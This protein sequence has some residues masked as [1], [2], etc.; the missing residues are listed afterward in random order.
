M[1]D[2]GPGNH[3]LHNLT[4]RWYARLSRSESAH[5][6]PPS[7]AVPFP[8]DLYDELDADNVVAFERQPQMLRVSGD[9]RTTIRSVP[10]RYVG[11][12]A[13]HPQGIGGP[14]HGRGKTPSTPLRLPVEAQEAPA[15]RFH[16][17]VLPWS[18]RLIAAVGLLMLV[19]LGLRLI[20]LPAPTLDSPLGVQATHAAYTKVLAGQLPAATE[21]GGFLLG[22]PPWN[23]VAPTN[24]LAGLPVFNWFSALGAHLGVPVEWVGRALSAVFSAVA[25]LALFAVVRRTA[26]SLAAVYA[27]LFFAVAPLSV[28]LGQKFSPATTIIAVQALA[29]L[30]LLGWRDTVSHAKPQGS[31]GRFL[32][33]LSMSGIA[34][35]VDPGSLFLAL[36]AAYLV[37]SV[38]GERLQVGLQG[39]NPRVAV[40]TWGDA[41]HRSAHRGKVVAYV[42]TLLIA[43]GAW[44]LYS[45][46]VDVLVL[47]AGDGV[48]GPSG[49]I[50][51]LFNYGT[52][53][54]LTGMTIG[55]VLSVIG[56]LLLVAGML[57]GA[58]QGTRGIFNVWLAAALLHALLDAGRLAR[59]DD[60]LLP[61]LLPACALV[62]IGASWAGTLPARVWRAITEQQ[63]DPVSEYAVSPH[64]AWLLD[65]PETPA[66]APAARPQA[67]P[68]LGRSVAA[69]T[70]KAGERAR[71]ASLMGFGH[72]AVLG[73]I[74]LVALSG[75]QAAWASAQVSTD[76]VELEAAGREIASISAPGSQIVIVGP[77]A[78]ELFYASGR[79]GWALDEESFSILEIAR[80]QRAGASYLLSADQTWLGQHP[81]YV[82]LLANYSVKQLA[83]RYILFD[84]NTKPS[85]NDRLYFLESGHTLG[86]AFRRYWETH[87]GVQKLGYPISEEVSEQNPLDGQVRI[88]QYFERAVLEHHPEFGG[89]QDEVMLAAVGLWVTKDRYFQQVAPFESTSERAYF[90]QTG[91]SVKE[92]FL[93][94]WNQQG[95]LA[96]FGYP[97]SEELP[98]IS[99]ADGKV[100]TVQYFERARFEWHPADA[101]TPNEV[102]LGLIGKQALEM[103]K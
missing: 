85:A 16:A 76:A 46:K 73:A 54:Q 84:L 99:P 31:T 51:N 64:T 37:L 39:R 60:V 5:S 49:L 18:G 40:A 78:P 25:A 8:P 14:V 11:R 89:T 66:E 80:L 13:R 90:P 100:Y 88:V 71:R 67:R 63:R 74:G 23:G 92:A 29:I 65:L 10:R 17:P 52:Y 47:G 93:R 75:W 32:A 98:E 9:D 35:L 24:P 27:T 95:G 12:S 2:Q 3:R 38:D 68:A 83:R 19:T 30:T 7:Q 44:W 43:A 61:V 50:A 42:A 34:A 15:R 4:E 69:R 28:T 86:G 77:H 87:G 26:G 70:Q 36:P 41:W 55:R 91:H 81:D 1:S 56:L 59:H 97:I 48:G 20:A 58:R 45:S 6:G 22:S 101:G 82:G 53:V 94:F 102:Q 33:A 96:A 103:R 79:T 62:G 21:Q 72:L 57:N